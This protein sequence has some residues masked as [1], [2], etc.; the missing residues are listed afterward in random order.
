MAVSPIGATIARR[1]VA[2]PGGGSPLRA[3]FGLKRAAEIA[4]SLGSH[5][6]DGYSRGIQ[7][8]SSAMVAA[9]RDPVLY[10]AG[11][12]NT[13]EG[14]ELRRKSEQLCEPRSHCDH[15]ACFTRTTA[16]ATEAEQKY[17][18][19]RFASDGACLRSASTA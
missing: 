18:Q 16:D 2:A 5:V 3:G 1:D 8:E 4:G 7:K 19:E 6:S 9:L 12:L 14:D 11:L 17:A 13:A 15:A 10:R